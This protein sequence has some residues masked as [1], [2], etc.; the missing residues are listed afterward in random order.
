[1]RGQVRLNHPF[2]H[3]LGTHHAQLARDRLDFS[4][5]VFVGED[6]VKGHLNRLVP[7]DFHEQLWRLGQCQRHKTRQRLPEAMWSQGLATWCGVQVERSRIGQQRLVDVGKRLRSIALVCGRYLRPQMLRA[8]VRRRTRARVRGCEACDAFGNLHESRL[9]R[10]CIDCSLRQL[11]VPPLALMSLH[12]L[13]GLA[14]CIRPAI[15]RAHDTA[16]LQ[17]KRFGLARTDAD[18]G[19]EVVSH[20]HGTENDQLRQRVAE[21]ATLKVV[22]LRPKKG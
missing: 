14:V 11:P 9:L 22:P 6:V 20:L 16:P 18:A 17:S 7:E 15:D 4:A 2:D 19:N 3:L 8:R 10:E 13:V 21:Q 1:L 12:K 5:E